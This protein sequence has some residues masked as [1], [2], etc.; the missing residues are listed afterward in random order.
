VVS[1]D[2]ADDPIVV[3]DGRAAVEEALGGA[4]I[5]GTGR[6]GKHLWLV[7]DDRPALLVHLGMTGALRAREQAPLVLEGSS[8][9]PDPSWPPRFTKLHLVLDDG[10]ELV[11]TNARRLGRLRLRADPKGSSPVADL[12]FDPLLALPDAGVFAASLRRRRGVLKGL[13]LDQRFAAGVGNWIAD[14][15]LFQAGI[16]PHRRA[17]DLSPAEA[18]ALRQALQDVVTTAVSVDARKDRFPSSWLFHRRWGRKPDQLTEDGHAIEHVT[19]GGR[20]TAW[21]PAVQR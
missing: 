19:L 10:A 9:D 5:T 8:A 12:G 1:V 7:L 20:T 13:L 11:F 17:N 18:E 21:V 4:R 3:E 14:E 6:W 15:V 2:C 16:A